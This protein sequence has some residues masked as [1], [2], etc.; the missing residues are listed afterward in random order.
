MCKCVVHVLYEESHSGNWIQW[1]TTIKE[2]SLYA[3]FDSHD[4]TSHPPVA[5]PLHVMIF[6]L[7]IY[8]LFILPYFEDSCMNPPKKYKKITQR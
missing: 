7:L 4:C 3:F 1:Q 2:F 5:L 8:M 6:G